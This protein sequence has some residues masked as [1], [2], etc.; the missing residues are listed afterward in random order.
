MELLRLATD[1]RLRAPCLQAQGTAGEGRR[2]R[3]GRAPAAPAPR[4]PSTPF[5][6]HGSA[7][8]A[9]LASLQ[10]G[11]ASGQRVR[12][13]T[14]GLN[15]TASSSLGPFRRLREAK[16]RE[17]AGRNE[18]R[19]DTSGKSG[20]WSPRDSPARRRLRRGRRRAER[21]AAPLDG[22]ELRGCG[23]REVPVPQADPTHLP[24]AGAPHSPGPRRPF[25][26]RH[27]CSQSGAPWAWSAAG[28][29]MPGAEAR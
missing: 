22:A 5:P 15:G 18:E 3:P 24:A 8:A 28:S 20:L 11:G 9:T 2:A 26:T 17:K 25:P 4:L 10:P 16:V 1:L 23:C 14:Q 12:T 27:R 21:G 13:R 29:N 6:L 7:A 19:G